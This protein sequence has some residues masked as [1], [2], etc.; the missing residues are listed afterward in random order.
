MM[1][2]IS[3]TIISLLDDI[4]PWFVSLTSVPFFPINV[5]SQAEPWVCTESSWHSSFLFVSLPLFYFSLIFCF[6]SHM[7]C[8]VTK[9]QDSSFPKMSPAYFFCLYLSGISVPFSKFSSSSKTNLNVPLTQKF[10]LPN[11]ISDSI[12]SNTVVCMY[13]FPLYWYKL[14]CCEI[15]SLSLYI[16]HCLVHCWH[17]AVIP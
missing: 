16:S 13:I 11:G 14:Q 2:F 15:L 17:M 7:H 9:L 8:A 12:A 1:I 6:S 10:A 3:V 4:D 5:L